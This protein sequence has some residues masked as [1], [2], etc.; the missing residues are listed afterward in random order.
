MI[1]CAWCIHFKIVK[2][3]V[4]WFESYFIFDNGPLIFVELPRK[5]QQ[6]NM[7]KA[8]REHTVS[9]QITKRLESLTPK[10]NFELYT[11]TIRKSKCSVLSFW[12]FTYRSE[13][14]V[15]FRNWD[16]SS[17]SDVNLLWVE[18]I[19]LWC[20]CPR[21]TEQTTDKIMSSWSIVVN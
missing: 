3:R 10:T 4:L 9:V 6:T 19:R 8:W 11:V 7:N 13:V 12:C 16:I 20:V 5:H 14:S 17:H 15:E 18:H 2:G 21:V 1:F